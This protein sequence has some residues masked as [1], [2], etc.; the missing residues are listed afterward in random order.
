MIRYTTLTVTTCLPVLVLA[1]LVEFAAAAPQ[2]PRAETSPKPAKQKG[3]APGE[4]L[5]PP[6][7][8]DLKAS[9]FQWLEQRNAEQPQLVEAVTPFWQFEGKPAPEQLF[10]ALMRTF[11]LADAE[12]RQ[13]VDACRH[14]NYSSDLLGAVVP[15]EQ[16]EEQEPLLT[17]NVRYYLARHF[18][19]LTAYND[20][21]KIFE[22]TDPKYVVDPAGYLF[23][24]AVCEQHLLLKEQGLKTLSALQNQ[25]ESV[26]MRYRKLA[27]L[28]QADLEQVQEK[29][30]GEVARQMKDVER[31]LSLKQTDTGVQQ[32]EEK[33]IATLDELIKKMEEQQQQQQSS[34]SSGGGSSSGQ[35]PQ[36][37]QKEASSGGE[38]PSANL[39]QAQGKG[40]QDNWGDLP[41]KAKEAAK[42]MLESDFPA[43]YRAAVEEYLKKLAERPAPS[44]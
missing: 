5:A 28:M 12:T 6:S 9:V 24:R 18:T 16:R 35:P 33:I 11:Y 21:L 7:A 20:A 38:M 37:Q 30:L 3:I 13:T 29:S 23:H 8:E 26:P 4:V 32:V 41:P 40:G 15:G 44:R 17:H 14:W 39:S 2:I 1:L 31:R 19:L 27:E 42:N 25:T 22:V 10:E 43:H 34:S 36:Q